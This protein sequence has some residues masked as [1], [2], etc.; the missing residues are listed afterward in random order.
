VLVQSFSDESLRRLARIAPQLARVQLLTRRAGDEDPERL[1]ARIAEYA[2]GVGPN[3]ALVDEAFMSAARRH[4]LLVHP[5]TVNDPAEME[6][7]LGLGV[8]GIFTD[9]PDLLRRRLAAE[10]G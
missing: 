1:L 10:G 5:W 3:A 8:D 4:G 9:L 7:L 6:R 2:Q